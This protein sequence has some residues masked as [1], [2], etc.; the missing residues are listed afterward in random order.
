[1]DGLASVADTAR[2]ASRVG[3]NPSGTAQAEAQIGAWTAFLGSL[4]HGN[5]GAA[6]VVGGGMGTANLVARLMTNP[7]FVTYLAKQSKTATPQAANIGQLVNMANNADDPDL[8]A[9]AGALAKYREPEAK[10][11][12]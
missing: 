11:G 7:R 5:I 12:Q 3:A 9:V 10:D 6:G 8:K 1:M 2:Q 4:A